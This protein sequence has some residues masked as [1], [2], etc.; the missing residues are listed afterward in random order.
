MVSP[1]LSGRG[2]ALAQRP[3][4][5]AE[6]FSLADHEPIG[7]A[8]ARLAE[9]AD[10]D[11]ICAL[12]RDVFGDVAKADPA[13][14]Q[15]QYWD[16]PYGQAVS[17]VWEDDSGLVAHYAA[18][19]VPARFGA[20]ECIGAKGAD[21][22]TAKSHR[23]Q[24]LFA[25]SAEAVYDEC[26]RRGIRVTQVTP[27]A[28]SFDAEVRA[29]ATPVAQ[30]PA[31]V[32]PLDVPWLAQR[33]HVPDD[34][35]RIAKAA[36]FHT[37]KVSPGRRLSA[38]PRDLDSLWAATA[39]W[40]PYG[41]VHDAKWFDWRYAQRPGGEY[42]FYELRRG[43]RL[44]GAAASALRRAYGASFVYVLDLL[45]EDEDAAAGLVRGLRR[46]A[47]DAAGLVAVALP[48]SR[49]AGLFRAAGLRRL[50][51]QLEPQPLHFGACDTAKRL[52]DLAA[53]PWTVSWSLADQL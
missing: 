34:V 13:T 35:A 1:G 9:A 45:A 47:G 37:P 31:Y 32:L 2:S 17:V 20:R 15:W 29:G 26:A 5:F 14:L 8:R 30:V 43:A 10:T 6:R 3:P 44:V 11:A 36:A 27:N 40:E 25:R 18:F 19:P 50:P 28:G 4:P 12:I 16:N 48:N 52:P 24:G 23:G 53:L 42:A 22:A 38:P 51:R 39:V 46:D 41:V 7:G 33:F 49:L 21:A